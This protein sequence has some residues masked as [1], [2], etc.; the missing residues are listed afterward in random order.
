MSGLR[1]VVP[2]LL[3]AAGVGAQDLLWRAEGTPDQ[4]RR[5]LAV[6]PLG[7]VDG[8]GFE[9]MVELVYRLVPEGPNM[10]GRPFT[11]IVSGRTGDVLSIG[12]RRGMDQ[13][14]FPES[15]TSVGDLD[16]DGIEDYAYTSHDNA[17]G[18][19]YLVVRSGADHRIL[20]TKWEYFGRQYGTAITGKLDV[21][22]DGSLDVLTHFAGANQNG[23]VLAY[24]AVGNLIWSLPN[25]DPNV[26]IAVAL[27]P[28]GGDLDHDGGDDFLMACPDVT[29]RGQ[30]IVVSGRTG[31]YLQ[32]GHGE[33]PGDAL[34][35]C[36][37]CGDLDGDG[38]L[39]FAG[40]GEWGL[41][42]VR[43]FSG[44]TGQPIGVPPV[45][46]DD[47]VRV[48]DGLVP[49]C[50]RLRPGRDQRH[51]DHRDRLP[52][53]RS[54]GP[55][56][57]RDVP[58]QRQP[59]AVRRV[60]RGD[61]GGG[62]A[63]AGGRAIP[64]RRVWRGLLHQPESPRLHDRRA[65]PRL[66]PPHLAAD[67]DDVRPADVVDRADLAHG[68]AQAVGDPARFTLSGAPP[69]A[70]GLLAFGIS[71]HTIGGVPLP[72]S[73][74]PLGLPGITLLTSTN[75]TRFA[76]TGTNGIAGGYAQVDL[77]VTFAAAAGIPLLAQWLWLD[78]ADVTR[79]GS[80]GAHRFVL[81]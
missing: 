19:A 51:L 22:G 57:R 45:R 28:L 3:V 73:L 64:D 68:H 42:I 72:L 29:G 59:L 80:T 33:L 71:S 81:Q 4:I 56:G 10:V 53:D 20:W 37:G 58:L 66:G 69:G 21:D 60:V 79:H 46:V 50:G 9:D 16:A 77:G 65:G 26:L 32:T 40:G 47:A 12:A 52:C 62:A 25:P 36:I 1:R 44:A 7:D 75:A 18:I 70:M 5:G 55:H 23:E 24:D 63:S 31:T 48:R 41:D 78:P 6:A 14:A 13:S 2:A 38:V 43:T 39:D 76:A 17:A 27:A 61:R 74:A 49:R 67:R 11:A 8:D 15:L 30:I 34:Y 35:N 54:V